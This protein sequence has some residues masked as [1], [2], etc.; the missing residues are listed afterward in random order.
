MSAVNREK[1]PCTSP[2]RLYELPLPSPCTTDTASDFREQATRVTPTPVQKLQR[3]RKRRAPAHAAP[4]RRATSSLTMLEKQQKHS[5][6]MPAE[7]RARGAVRPPRHRHCLQDV[8]AVPTRLI[9]KSACTKT[10]TK[11][12]RQKQAD[13]KADCLVVSPACRFAATP[14]RCRAV[15][16]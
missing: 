4:V 13:Q 9:A 7:A 1:M 2:G 14:W 5:L 12:K 11:R 3:A 10:E 8:D 16:R 6:S 15:Q